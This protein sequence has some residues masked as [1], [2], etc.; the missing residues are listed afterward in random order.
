LSCLTSTAYLNTADL[1]LKTVKITY[2]KSTGMEL[3][4]SLVASKASEYRRREPLFD[5]EQERIETLPAAF[6]NDEFHWRDA[7]WVVRWYFR[8]FLGEYPH[9]DRQATESAFR[10]NDFETVQEALQAVTRTDD[11]AAQVDQL[12]ALEGVDVP[13]ASAFLLFLDPDENV[14]VGEREWSVLHEAGELPGAYPDPPSTGE[15]ERYVAVCREL[16]DRFDCST[17]MLYQA[18]WRLAN[19]AVAE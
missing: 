13:V 6:G 8:R 2:A 4:V 7:E 18:L 16:A 19:E 10:A 3:S 12:T 17:W 1:A 14:V 9:E 15:Y 5:V 11:I